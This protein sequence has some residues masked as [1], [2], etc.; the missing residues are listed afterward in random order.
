MKVHYLNDQPGRPTGPSNKDKSMKKL[1]ISNIQKPAH[2]DKLA[3]KTAQSVVSSKQRSKPGKDKFPF[4]GLSLRSNCRCGI[5]DVFK[6]SITVIGKNGHVT[7]RYYYC[8]KVR[9]ES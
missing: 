8:R 6:N 4:I 9:N 5:S 7:V 1:A 2:N 3:H